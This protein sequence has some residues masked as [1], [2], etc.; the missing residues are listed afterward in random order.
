MNV[1][2]KLM[3]W[4]LNFICL[5]TMHLLCVVYAIYCLIQIVEWV[6][7]LIV[8]VIGLLSILLGFMKKY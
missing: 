5:Y 6:Q 1:F 4:P 7:I 3:S 8:L 2:V